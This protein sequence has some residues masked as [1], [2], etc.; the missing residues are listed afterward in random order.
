MYNFAPCIGGEM[1]KETAEQ[2][3]YRKVEEKVVKAIRG[4]GMVNDGDRILIGLSGGKDSIALVDLLGRR[5]KIHRPKFEVVVAHIIMT[6][7]P[8][9]ADTDYLRSCAEEHGLPFV[10]RETS[11]DASTDQRKSPCF[12][13]SWTRRKA[14][15]DIAKAEGCNKIALG[16]HQDDIL[17]TLLMNITHQGAFGTMPPR[18][19]MDKFDMEIIRPLCLVPEKDLIAIASWKEYRKLF[20]NCPYESGSSRSDMKDVLHQLERINPEARFSLWNSMTNIQ[21]DYLPIKIK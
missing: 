8:Y 3:I 21:K 6:N 19:K 17:Q 1:A 9:H 13:C 4:Y 5:A 20:K 18:L 14:L 10:I 7:I 11:F 15:F 16:H 12:L 2:R